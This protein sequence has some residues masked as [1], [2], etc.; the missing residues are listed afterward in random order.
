M[1]ASN[2]SEV[3]MTP[4]QKIVWEKTLNED[5]SLLL[6]PELEH[7]LE[8]MVLR[9]LTLGSNR[10]RRI[11][12]RIGKGA[13]AKV[14]RFGDLA[15]KVIGGRDWSYLPLL[16]DLQAELTLAEIVGDKNLMTNGYAISAQQPLGARINV[17]GNP[18]RAIIA[19]PF[20]PGR[21]FKDKHDDILLQWATERSLYEAMAHAK[22]PD[23]S[24]VL[25]SHQENYLIG[26]GRITKID[27]RAGAK[28]TQ[29]MGG[30]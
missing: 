10:L 4:T 27:T 23:D 5:E 13:F 16:Q 11:G 24:L 28:F 2:T 8:N 9:A 26:D 22:L 12:R 30:I 15:V 17:D 21:T 7:D 1:T 25:D 6:D 14:Y 19:I 3:S 20:I 18:T 29:L